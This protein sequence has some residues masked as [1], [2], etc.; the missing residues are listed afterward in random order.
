M[1]DQ[2]DDPPRVQPGPPHDERNLL[3]KAKDE[4][5]A[6][7]GDADAAGRRQRDLAAGDHTGKGPET[8]LEPDERIIDEVSHRL[9]EDSV[10]D[11]S[12]IEVESH[13][14]A[15]TLIGEVTT[16]A[17]RAHAEEVAVKVAGVHQV[18]NRLQVA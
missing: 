13:D 14:G 8:Q 3:E 5:Q 16:S 9:T 6:W 18:E 12:R 11:A 7:F 15:V 17:E 2:R 1:T 4:V 10:I